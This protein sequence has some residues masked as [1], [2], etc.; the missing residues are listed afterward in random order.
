MSWLKPSPPKKRVNWKQ[1]IK[2]ERNKVLNEAIDTIKQDMRSKP[3][4]W[5]RGY[6]SAITELEKLKND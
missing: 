1:E 4:E 6:Y 2:K 3:T 5:N